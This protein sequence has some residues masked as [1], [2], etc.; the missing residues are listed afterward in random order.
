MT[1]VKLRHP[2]PANK[3]TGRDLHQLSPTPG[4]AESLQSRTELYE[5]TE[6]VPLTA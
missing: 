1:D 5:I 6:L 2:W 3:S 4:L